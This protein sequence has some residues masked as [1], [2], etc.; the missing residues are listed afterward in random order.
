MKAVVSGLAI[1]PVKGTRLRPVESVRLD[2]HGVR[3]NRRFF[4]IDHQ[5]NMVNSTH[6]GK[7]Q[8]VVSTY[9]DEDRRLSL[10]FPDGRLLE[11]GVRLGDEVVT[12]FYKDTT[13]ARLVIG[14]WSTA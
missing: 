5:N 8:T 4:L 9:S 7:L 12:R 11:D 13:P 6:L 14:E 10:E 1:T 2:R 3:G